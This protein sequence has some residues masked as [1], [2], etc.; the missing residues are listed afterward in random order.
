MKSKDNVDGSRHG[1][2]SPAR[3]TKPSTLLSLMTND[4]NSQLLIARFLEWKHRF[5]DGTC[6]ILRVADELSKLRERIYDQHASFPSVR[7]SD[8]S[9]NNLLPRCAKIF[10]LLQLVSFSPEQDMQIF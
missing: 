9:S 2:A 10:T 7:L 4:P 6:A 5:E 1:R 8:G 3:L